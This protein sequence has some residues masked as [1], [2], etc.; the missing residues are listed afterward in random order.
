MRIVKIEHSTGV[1]DA[2]KCEYD[3]DRLGVKVKRFG[4]A[5]IALSNM[6]NNNDIQNIIHDNHGQE[7]DPSDDDIQ[8]FNQ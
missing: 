6:H 5:V 2:V 3:L 7:V 1:L 4:A 8:V